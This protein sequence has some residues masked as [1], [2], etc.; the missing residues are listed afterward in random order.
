MPKAAELT[1]QLEAA[2]ARELRRTYEELNS[3]YF[4]GAL[5]QPTI[6]L[7]DATSRLGR[8]RGDVRTL[9]IGR[10]CALDQPW[11]VVVEVL[12]HEMAHQYVE[13]VLGENAQAPHGNAFRETCTRLGVDGSA[14][15]LPSMIE[16]APQAG[17]QRLLERVAKLLA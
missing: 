6:E 14:T 12:K 9:E 4:K 11:G 2:L 16:G 1:A 15:G 13:E 10:A 8:W 3:C 7:S 5:R 17:D